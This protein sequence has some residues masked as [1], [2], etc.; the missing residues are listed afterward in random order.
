MWD[1]VTDRAP[2]L[3][4]SK[5][6]FWMSCALLVFGYGVAV[7]SFNLFP[8]RWLKAGT[9]A[10]RTL[11]DEWRTA[12]GVAPR[13]FLHRSSGANAGVTRYDAR[14][15]QPGLTLLVGFLD[16]HNE[17]RLI[18]PDGEI[19][20][21]WLVRFFD[22]FP[23]P[24]HIA[25]RKDIPKG[26]WN[27]ELHG[28]L[29]LPDG[30]VVFN[31]EYAGLVKLDRCGAVQWTVPRMT[32]HSV[33]PAEGGGAW[34][35]S[36]RYIASN[37]PRPELRAP[38]QDETLL[39][40][41]PTGEIVDEISIVDVMLR[42]KLHGLL[43]AMDPILHVPNDWVPHANDV[44]ELAG[45]MA[46]RFPMFKTGD[47]L[48]SSRGMN[49]IMV[50]NPSTRTVVW[51]KIGQWIAQHDPDFQPN[52]TIT[53][54]NNNYDGTIHGSV[55]AGSNIVEI[56]PLSGDVRLL[57][58]GDPRAPMY[59]SQMGKHQYLHPSGN[60]LITESLKGR[61]LEVDTSGHVVWE[62]VN[63]YDPDNV[64]TLT[65][66]TKYPQDYF[67]VRDWTCAGSTGPH[68]P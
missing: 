25:P 56:D 31:F 55:W 24:E 4:L 46:D 44:E 40:V 62:Y 2:R 58:Q 22:L 36:R 45:A 33:E 8:Y 32:H 3:D 61:A 37:S 21:R 1:A 38:Y 7:G 10:M 66:A 48:V 34:V 60:I 5:G 15:T 11:R 18:R 52:G 47:L 59:S 35:S 54:F 63:R 43:F 30:S 20:R 65:Q 12:L 16:G 57:Y 29:A 41:S 17:L 50:V 51:H 14:G 27:V 6:V 19:V 39:K 42:S 13:F 9:E 64:A 28:A 67:S 53:L 68:T 49:L 23:N 26:E